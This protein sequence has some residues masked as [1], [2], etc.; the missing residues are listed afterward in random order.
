MKHAALH[1][2]MGVFRPS[3]KCNCYDLTC[4]HAAEGTP[5]VP[6]GLC[7][8]NMPYVFGH[9]F[10]KGAKAESFPLVGEVQYVFQ[11]SG[12]QTMRLVLRKWSLLNEDKRPC[13]VKFLEEVHAAPWLTKVSS[14]KHSTSANNSLLISVR[15]FRGEDFFFSSTCSVCSLSTSSFLSYISFSACTG[16]WNKEG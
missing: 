14:D 16:D 15:N 6:T 13:I 2:H 11:G 10:K 9:N 12:T 8:S 3:A 7:S 5:Y 4:W 1:L